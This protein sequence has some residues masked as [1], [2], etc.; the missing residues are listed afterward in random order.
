MTGYIKLLLSIAAVAG[1]AQVANAQTAI[2]SPRISADSSGSGGS[3]APRGSSN[4]WA[5]AAGA[6]MEVV[7]VSNDV[8]GQGVSYVLVRREGDQV[9]ASERI[10]ASEAAAFRNL[11][12]PT[13]DLNEARLIVG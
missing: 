6:G 3:L 7:E 11:D 10:G 2:S 8:A 9:I 1:C 12:C 5:C 13:R 4:R